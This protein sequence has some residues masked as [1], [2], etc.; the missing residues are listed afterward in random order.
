MEGN[1]HAAMADR[2]RLLESRYGDQTHHTRVAGPD[3]IAA[4]KKKRA[5]QRRAAVRALQG[6]EDEDF[7]PLS[8]PRAASRAVTTAADAD[9]GPHPHSGLQREEDD[10]GSGEDEHAEFTGATERIPLGRDAER[11]RKQE[12]RRQMRSLIAEATGAPDEEEDIAIVVRE[13]PRRAA[14][15]APSG[16]A[17]MTIHEPVPMETDTVLVRDEDPEEREEQEAWERAQLRRMDM[18]GMRV[19]REER[20]PSP[21]RA[22][23]V[24]LTAPVPTPTSCL[25][26]LQAQITS[27]DAR[28]TEEQEH[29][30]ATQRALD[31]LEHD[32][33]ALK[34]SVEAAE[35]KSAWFAELD[36]FVETFAAF[37]DVKMPLLDTLEH[38][39]LGLLVDRKVSR[40]R[41]R[42]LALEDALA[43]FH[44]VSDATLWLPHGDDESRPINADGDGTSPVR[45]ARRALWD[46][47]PDTSD[48]RLA[49]AERQLFLAGR[50]E[51]AEDV[52]RLLRDTHA[53]EFRSPLAADDTGAWHPRSLA[54]RFQAWRTA[55]PAEYDLAW[56]GLALANAWEFFA[57]YELVQWDPLWCTNRT[58][59]ETEVCLQ[60][61]RAG[62]EGF[63]FEH[64]ITAYVDADPRDAQKARG[65]DSEASAT[66]VSNAVVPRLVAVAEQAYDVWSEI[67]TASALVLVEQ[68][69]YLIDPT[70][71]RFQSLVR[72]FLAPFAAHVELLATAL[73]APRTAPG[74]PMHPDVP[75]A[76]AFVAREVTTLAL[77]LGRWGM[78]YHGPQALPWSASERGAYDTLADRLLGEVLWPIAVDA[79]AWGGREAAQGLV[80]RFP[81][82]VLP[83]DVRGRWEAL[84]AKD[85]L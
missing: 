39:A 78:Y 59:G 62:L 47:V 75:A 15:T 1:A 27:L 42:S 5:E 80:A 14:P 53:P 82:H 76:R 58:P 28:A 81:L 10:L 65:G 9:Q 45:T 19:E 21:H 55:Y 25:A 35:A 20:A 51:L 41:A 17:T 24:P 85:T 32:E 38:N 73:R 83:S 34:R 57:R 3:T 8:A 12:Q 40:Q 63:A 77:N 67:E 4:A 18:P 72:A 36:A 26:R 7:I 79:G 31:A 56:G 30:D 23:P 48:Q 44:G 64:E 2:A 84:A 69:S 13:P 11:R 16:A 33:A 22:A 54:A 37:L 29:R 61:P 70:G 52:A 43:L 6:D 74:A 71:W 60:G 49:P 46:A 68:V 66:L 50:S